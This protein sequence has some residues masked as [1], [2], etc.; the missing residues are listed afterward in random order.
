MAPKRSIATSMPLGMVLAIPSV[1]SGH[2]SVSAEYDSDNEVTLKD[3]VSKIAFV[4]PHAALYIDVTNKD[5]GGGRQ[6]LGR[7]DQ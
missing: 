2:H 3:V 7:G 4:N 6:Q 5:G 1:V